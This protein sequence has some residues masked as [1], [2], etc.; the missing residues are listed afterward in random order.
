VVI[1]K[2]EEEAVRVRRRKTKERAKE[3]PTVHQL[4]IRTRRAKRA[5]PRSVL[6][7]CLNCPVEA[8]R[9]REAAARVND[10]S[11]LPRRIRAERI[12]EAVKAI[13]VLGSSLWRR[14]APLL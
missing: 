4:T 2:A 13:F 11:S 1:K 10:S 12:S 3:G 5:R 7:Q 14:L 6:S 8:T 9:A